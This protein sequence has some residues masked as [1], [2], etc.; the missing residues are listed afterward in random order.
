MDSWVVSSFH[1]LLYIRVSSRISTNQLTFCFFSRGAKNGKEKAN[2]VSRCR[3]PSRHASRT[4]GPQTDPGK[5]KATEAVSSHDSQLIKCQ[6][7][8]K[9]GVLRYTEYT[10]LFY[11]TLFSGQTSMFRKPMVYCDVFCPFGEIQ[12]W[13]RTSFYMSASIKTPSRNLV[14]TLWLRVNEDPCAIGFLEG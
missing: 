1:L 12:Y 10:A 5:W 7:C 3:C 8:L 9:I 4:G 6:W 13:D 11:C 14:C 2:R